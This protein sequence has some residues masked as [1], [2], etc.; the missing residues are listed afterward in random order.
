MSLAFVGNMEESED[1]WVVRVRVKRRG[2]DM[3]HGSK[4]LGTRGIHSSIRDHY[5][6]SNNKL[7]QMTN[8]LSH[9]RARGH[10]AL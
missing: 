6:K 8:R 9:T 4:P 5:A 1:T 10:R 3:T 7:L 2:K